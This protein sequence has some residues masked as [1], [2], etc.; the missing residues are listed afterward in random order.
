MNA[1][2]YA[3]VVVLWGTTWI[4]ISVQGQ[5]EIAASVAVF[6]RF[7]ISAALLFGLLL[8]TRRLKS[9]SLKD[10]SFCMLQGCCVFGFNFVCFYIAIHYI[11]SGLEAVIFSMAVLFNAINAKLFFNTP[12][13]A[14]FYPAACLGL[15]GMLALFWQD[16]IGTE[17][18]RN[19]LIGIA[20]C[21]LGTYGFSLGN[22]ISARHQKQGLDIFNT[23]AYAMF[24]GA[25]LMAMISLGLQQDF[26][27]AMSVP[28]LTALFYLAIFGSVIG[29]TAYFALVGRIGASQA[30]YS[31]LLFPL[32][33][34]SISTFWENYQWHW[35][36]VLGVLLILSGN[37]L[38]FIRKSPKAIASKPA[39][40]A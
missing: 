29:F 21:M 35:S 7:F 6:W 4:A 24:Y 2:L 27:P 22:M 26:L 19:T 12:I 14:R 10:H 28:S 9:M 13:V 38:F 17:L 15:L 33:A 3:L 5:S 1:L 32:V 25:M 11:N 37:A 23:N 30:A 31:T 34:L 20:L 8:L 16:L 18:N 40:S 36:A 39:Q